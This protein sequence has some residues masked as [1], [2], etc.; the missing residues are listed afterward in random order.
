MASLIKQPGGAICIGGLHPS[1]PAHLLLGPH[2]GTPAATIN[3]APSLRG[4]LRGP[5]S[6]SQ[7]CNFS[8]LFFL[9]PQQHLVQLTSPLLQSD[10]QIP[11]CILSELSPMSLRQ[12]RAHARILGAR[13]PSSSISFTEYRFGAKSVLR[14][15]TPEGTKVHSFMTKAFQVLC[16]GTKAD[17][18]LAFVDLTILWERQILNT[19]YQI[20]V[21]IYA[22]N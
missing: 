10:T 3:W 4:H 22:T 1:L 7:L 2:A 15:R 5:T 13:S 9:D 12:L 16:S 6:C 20:I 8:V 18:L 17:L 21:M 11:V 14:S 19:F